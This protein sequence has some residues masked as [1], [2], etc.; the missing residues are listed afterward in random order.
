MLYERTRAT[1]AIS[2]AA[3]AMNIAGDVVLV[4]A[5]GA[6]AIGPAVASLAAMSVIAIGYLVVAGR[7]LGV[8]PRLSPVAAIAP[9]ASIAASLALPIGAALL[10]GVAA[11]VIGAVASVATGLCSREDLT[12]LREFR[13][14]RGAPAPSD[15]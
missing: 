5:L 12:Q 2:V 4:G 8:R 11:T 15:G 10:T 1:A 7:M 3:L 14:R 6:G 13:R 9:A